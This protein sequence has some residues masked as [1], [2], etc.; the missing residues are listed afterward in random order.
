MGMDHRDLSW[1]WVPVGIPWIDPRAEVAADERLVRN[2]FVSRQY[3]AKHRGLRDWW[4]TV[5]ELAEEQTAMA[6]NGVH[7]Q[8]ADPG[9]VTAPAA[10]AAAGFDINNGKEGEP[11]AQDLELVG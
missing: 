3:I 6:E 9:A 1:E 7:V 8:V 11:E 10:D 5:E 4:Q 2:G